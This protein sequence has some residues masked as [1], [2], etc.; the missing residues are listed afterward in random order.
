M[1]W[2]KS[3]LSG[4][5]QCVRINNEC[6]SWISVLS[7][8]PQGSVLGPILFVLFINDLPDV[9]NSCIQLFADDAKI[10]D[11]V[12]LREEQS[13]TSLQNDIDSLF[14]WSIP[15]SARFY[16]SEGLIPA[17]DIKSMETH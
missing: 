1:A 10:F 7:G 8:I 13:G 17:V 16:T 2:I 14:E 11:S 9:V 5:K 4:R 15:P 12:H 6:S 3:F